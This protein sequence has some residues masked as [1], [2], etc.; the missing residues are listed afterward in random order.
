[1]KKWISCL[2]AAAI[3]FVTMGAHAVTVSAENTTNTDDLSFEMKINSKN[4]SVPLKAPLNKGDTVDVTFHIHGG[5]V[6][7]LGGYLE[8]DDA[9]LHYEKLTTAEISQTTVEESREWVPNDPLR[10][11]NRLYVRSSDWRPVK[12]QS[13]GLILTISFTLLKSVPK[14]NIALNGVW[15]NE[16]QYMKDYSL[17]IENEKAKKFSL[18]TEPESGYDSIR[19]PVKFT[20]TESFSSLKISVGYNSAKLMFDSVTLS[21]ECKKDVTY[22]VGLQQPPSQ[23]GLQSEVPITFDI[24]GEINGTNKIKILCY[25][26]FHAL[27]AAGGAGTGTGTGTGATSAETI[28]WV[29]IVAEEVT[30]KDK[31]TNQVKDVFVLDPAMA[32]SQVTIT[33]KSQNTGSTER[34]KLVILGTESVSG[35]DM[36]TVP[37]NLMV[38]EGFSSLGISATF[39]PAKLIYDSVVISDVYRNNVQLDSYTMSQTGSKLTVNLT[40]KGDIK[41]TGTLMYLNFRVSNL[42]AASG[43]G[44]QASATK[45]GPTPVVLNVETVDKLTPSELQYV[46]TTTSTVTITEREHLAGDVNG[47]NRIDLIDVLYVI[48][49]YNDV[50]KLTDVEFRAADMDKNGVVNLIDARIMLQYY[51]SEL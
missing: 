44:T 30:N 37:V 14:V 28:E 2:L 42:P 3:I 39:D 36:I 35:Y 38:N 13:D 32:Y 41:T 50:K 22:T 11:N 15:V 26:N 45:L 17:P 16:N 24:P 51:D 23:S 19:V 46:A 7:E 6:F 8:Y 49:Y 47:N 18:W 12:P 4:S 43:T 20:S 10:D 25:L 27:P 40:S 29:N 48:Q 9:V 34:T 31:G 1:M 5:E 21:E 33:R